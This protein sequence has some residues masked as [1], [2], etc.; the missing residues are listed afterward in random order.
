VVAG[1]P[2]DPNTAVTESE[3]AGHVQKTIGA[4]VRRLVKEKRGTKLH[5]SRPVG[6]K[7]RLTQSET[8]K[9][10]NYCGLALKRSV[11]NLEVMKRAVWAVFLRELLT[12]EKPPDGVCTS[13]GDIWCKFKISA[14]S[15]VAYEHKHP[16]PAAVMD[17]ITPVFRDHAGVDPLKKCF[18]G[19]IH[20]PTEY[21]NPVI[22]T[23]IS[24]TVFIRLDTFKF[25]IYN[26][27]LCF[28][29][30]VTERNVLNMLGMRSG[31][32]Q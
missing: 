7:G 29:N 28:N 11:N 10:Q 27:L 22:W 13:G 20:N 5:D 4:R 2:Y 21:M 8:D 16:L 32:N 15:G 24:K 26:A 31:S 18:H 19:K 9:L 25:G 14:G 3:C 6:G 1:K 17:A 30:G 12:N 23:G